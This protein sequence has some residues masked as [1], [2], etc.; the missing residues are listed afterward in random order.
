MILADTL[1]AKDLYI[2][3]ISMTNYKPSSQTYFD[4]L[5]QN[6]L[7]GCWDQIYILPRKITLY[8]YMRC[9]QYKIIKNIL[10][11]NKKL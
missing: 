7:S 8:S 1:T 6:N 5:L 9:F 4:N 10:F 11:L 3:L 2:K